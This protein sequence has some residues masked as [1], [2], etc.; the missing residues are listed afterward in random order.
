MSQALAGLNVLDLTMNLPG[1]Y[2]TWLLAAMG[3]EVVKVENPTGGDYARM[4]G[5]SQDSPFFAAVN[6]NKKSLALDLKH[7]EGQRLFLKL[8]DT[9][10]VLVEGFRPGTMERLGLSFDSISL[11]NPRL[12]Y[13]SITGYGHN[14][15]YRL[16]A[17]HDVNY[18]SLA[19]IIGMT[20][21]REGDLAI[22]GVQ[23]ADLAGGSLMA[24]SGL[25]AAIIQRE[26]TGRGQFVDVAMFDGALSLATMLFGGVQAG[27]ERPEA[28]KMFLNGRFPCYGLYK[29]RDGKYMS[30]GALES[31]FWENFC[32]AVNRK[33]LVGEQ[34]GGEDIVA[35]VQRIFASRSRD[36]WVNLLRDSDGCCEPV[37]SLTEA[38]ESPLAE[39]RNMVT[40]SPDG[41]R[42]LASPIKLSDSP[43][44]DDQPAPD[45]GQDTREILSKLGLSDED[46]AS[47][48]EQRVIGT[49]KL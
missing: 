15:P 48:V 16:Q 45:L 42:F 28:G 17:G 22:P 47:L 31:K 9:Y 44:K 21:T 26:R 2:M 12:I 20:G 25:L 27:L 5:W 46:L 38:V 4:H 23:I 1:P 6:R 39:A 40:R 18:L 19:G 32:I 35:E 14:S 7:P 24:L 10:D 30:L 33:D 8:A 43:A 29:T 11:R 49:M 41:G 3:A 36:E 34:F 37:L 13:V